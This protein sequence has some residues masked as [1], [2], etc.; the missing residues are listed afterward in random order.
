MR[1]D[2]KAEVGMTKIITIILISLVGV[3]AI[4][5]G[6]VKY[7][8]TTSTETKGPCTTDANC[9]SGYE[10]VSGN[11]VKSAVASNYI[12]FSQIAYKFDFQARDGSD[13]QDNEVDLDIDCF[14]YDADCNA[15]SKEDSYF[16][17]SGVT[18]VKWDGD[19]NSASGVQI[20][21][22]N[23]CKVGWYKFWSE[24]TAGNEE[25]SIDDNCDTV[26]KG[27]DR[28]PYS[29]NSSDYVLM[30]SGNQ[31]VCTAVDTGEKEDA[32]P[33]AVLIEVPTKTN[34]ESTSITDKTADVI[35]KYKYHSDALTHSKTKVSIDCDD[36]DG[37]QPSMTDS[38]LN[39][40][41]DTSLTTA[42]TLSWVKCDLEV[43]ITEDGYLLPLVNPLPDSDVEKGYLL[44]EP[45]GFNFTGSSTN[46]NSTGEDETG[47]NP[48]LSGSSVVYD[49][50]AFING[51]P[52][53]GSTVCGV[54]MTSNSVTDAIINGNEYIYPEEATCLK[55]IKDDG[56]T[57]T[58]PIKL[59]TVP[60]KYV[61]ENNS[62][63]Y[64]N[65]GEEVMDISVVTVLNSTGDV[66]GQDLTG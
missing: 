63:I 26:S 4:G 57:M 12:S 20:T 21:E 8:Q 17:C 3:G 11:C 24:F 35:L 18:P 33:F 39:G 2:K 47:C 6:I 38:S 1:L 16:D 56:A 19:S 37:N 36:S 31:Y 55:N 50:S 29:S 5:F 7:V 54:Q 51:I 9:P 49:T 60:V 23:L 15:G 22:K 40:F 14:E 32:I 64:I 44:V 42:K 45:M 34:Y 41:V 43:E 61:S 58:L 53:G 59:S 10:C 46:C 25:T 52:Y 48:K 27:T 30:A 65:T 62:D 66:I 13:A 28:D